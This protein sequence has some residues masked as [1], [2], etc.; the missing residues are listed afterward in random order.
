MIAPTLLAALARA[1]AGAAIC[2]AAAGAA[3]AAETTTAPT[4]GLQEVIVT[5]QKRAES[6]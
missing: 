2:L 6:E 3:N 1:G 4:G 5:A